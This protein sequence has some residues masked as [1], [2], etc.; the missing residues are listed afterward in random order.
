M[1][2]P[3]NP[4]RKSDVEVSI[5]RAGRKDDSDIFECRRC[6]FLFESKADCRDH[7]KS[8]HEVSDE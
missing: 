6:G 4:E 5:V 8:Q 2:I 7:V 3:A 1:A